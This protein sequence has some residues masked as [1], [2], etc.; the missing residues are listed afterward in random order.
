LNKLLNDQCKNKIICPLNNELI[1][2]AVSTTKDSKNI[3]EKTSL[4]E[5]VRK[6]NKHPI[7]N[8]KC[9]LSDIVIN[10]AATD[11]IVI[12]KDAILDESNE[13]LFKNINIKIK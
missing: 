12:L 2:T 3:F 11:L 4:I 10:D 8:K 7:T 6:Y 5:Y 9:K 13:I 1:T